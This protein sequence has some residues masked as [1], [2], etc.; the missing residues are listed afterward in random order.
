MQRGFGECTYTDGS[1]YEGDL[2]IGKKQGHREITYKDDTVFLGHFQ[3][4][5]TH[6]P[7]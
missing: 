6:G 4:D 3:E 1:A 5:M 7:R 2:F